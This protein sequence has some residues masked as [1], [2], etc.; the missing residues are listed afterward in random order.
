[1]NTSNSN[2]TIS[3]A[4]LTL[5]AMLTMTLSASVMYAQQTLPYSYGFETDDLDADGWIATDTNSSGVDPDAA[6]TGENGF[7]LGDEYL[8]SPILTGGTN[9]VNVSFYY[10]AYDASWPDQFKVGY[11]TDDATKDDP[12]QFTY[13]DLITAWGSWQQY[14]NTFPA[15]TVRVAILHD[16]GLFLYLD[17]FSFEAASDCAAPTNLSVNYTS[18]STTATVTWGGN[19]DSYNI[20][21]NGTVT[22]GVTS[23][24]TLNVSGGTT[25]TIKVQADCGNEQSGWVLAPSFVTGCPNSYA[26]PYAYNFEDLAGIGCWEVSPEVRLNMTGISNDDSNSFFRFDQ[27]DAPQYLISPQLSGITNGLHVEFWYWDDNNVETFQVGYSTTDDDPASFVWG[28]EITASN[29]YQR[30]SANYRLAG[31]KYVAVKTSIVQDNLYLDDFLFEEVATVPEP[32]GVQ[33]GDIT[34]TEASISWTAGGSETA[35]D[36]F[37]TDDANVR[38]D[39]NTTPTVVNTS[40]NPYSLA[41]LTSCTIYYVYVRANTGTETSAWSSAAIF[42][43]ACE[44][45]ALPY[46][47]GFED[48]DLPVSWNTIVTDASNTGISVFNN[49]LSFCFF[50]D[51]NGTLAAVLP[52]VA[53][54]YPLNGCQI[55]FDACYTNAG[56]TNMTSG[57]LGIGVMTDPADFSTFELVKEVDITV[58]YGNQNLQPHTVWLNNYTGNGHYIAIQD[59][60]SQR[61][62]VYIDNINVTEL[63]SSLPPT[64]L[65]ANVSSNSATLSW[66]DNNNGGSTSFTL[67]YKKSTDQEYTSIENVTENHYTLTNLTAHKDYE[68]YVVANCSD[69]ASDPSETCSFITKWEPITIT[70]GTPYT[71]DFETPVVTSV[72]DSTTDLEVPDCWENPYTTGSYAAGK[73]HLIMDGAEYNYGTG[74]VL[75]F[76]GSGTNYITLPEFTNAI[77]T[78]AIS[79]KW[80]T[81]SSTDG[82]LCL[83]YITDGDDGTYDTFTPIKSYAAS[84]ASNHQLEQKAIGLSNVPAEAT[85]LVFRWYE[86]TWNGCNIDDMEVFIPADITLANNATNNSTTIAA[87]DGKTVNVTLSGRTLLKDGGWNTLCLPFDLDAAQVTAQLENPTA[88]MKLNGTTSNLANGTLT[89]IFDDATEIRAGVPYIIKWDDGENIENPS[90]AGVT[91]DKDASTEVTFTGGKFV[92]TYDYQSF[93]KEDKS[94]LLLGDENT[95]YYPQSGASIGACRAYFQVN[96]TSGVRAFVLNFGEVDGISLTPSPSRG[97]EGSIYTLNGVKLDKMPTRKGLY[98]NNGRKVVIK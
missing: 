27:T 16:D 60:C 79:F 75:Y 87:N 51:S 15:G 29:S 50:S 84:S 76:Y 28:D 93:D 92:G 57:K 72:F 25:Y 62:Y 5:L 12:S 4:V 66:T 8:V 46:S 91:I 68:F 78:L 61:G 53:D 52:E 30:F 22:T 85:R 59:I 39:E 71:Q 35:W 88:L 82:T 36:I 14:E 65:A 20:K 96:S 19:A 63:P 13:G 2:N 43:T 18:G 95:L 47:Y 3:R 48:A 42:H 49:I 40:V 67:Y 94:I 86:S 24:Y 26:I 98:I 81:E 58:A 56:N 23:P 31:I 7:S 38:P 44:P 80:A 83:G 73:P 45:I 33:A 70:A 55:S 21:V 32:T 1:M 90:F 41:G 6:H 17:D 54:T 10:R 9:G 11:T 97:G 37:M 69:E 34:T 89:L 74:Q 64:N 77:N